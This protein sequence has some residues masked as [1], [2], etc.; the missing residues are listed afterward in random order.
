MN[1]QNISI[2]ICGLGF[3][4][5][6]MQQSFE[7]NGFI[8]NKNLFLYDKFREIG[9]FDNLLKA[10]ILFLALPTSYNDKNQSYD[11]GPLNETLEKLMHNTYHGITVIKSTMC[12][13]TTDNFYNKYK[14]NLIHNPEFLTARTAFDDFHNQNL[15]V[16]GQ[17]KNCDQD[18][19]ELVRKFYEQFYPDAQINICEATESESMK[20]F[21]N[22]FYATKIQFFNEMYLLCQKTG[23][24]Y[25]TVKNLMLSYGWINP[26]H[27]DVPGHDGKLSFG[28][29]CFPKDTSAMLAFMKDNDSPHEVIEAVISERNEMRKN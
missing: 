15:I 21:G 1:V 9:T 10:D 17:N 16:L 2:G 22:C 4:G 20:L 5:S 23:A 19:V 6:A 11:L 18:K 25:N 7:K 12:P 24:D 3:V 29:G 26:N 28:G 13:Q 14:L 8:V 27:T